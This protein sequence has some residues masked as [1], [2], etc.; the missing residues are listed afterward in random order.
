MGKLE[1]TFILPPFS[2]FDTKQG[3]WQS[4]KRKWMELG[5]RSEEGRGDNLLKFSKTVQMKKNREFTS[6]YEGGD[7][8]AGSGTS[9]FDPVLCEI[10]Y[11]WFCPLNGKIFDNFAGGSV[12]GIV[13]A[14]LGYKYTGIDLSETQIVA[15]RKQAEELV[16]ENKPKWI[17]GD[18][19]KSL[20]LDEDTDYDLIFTCP[21]YYDLE[22]YSDG[23]NDMST[24][25]DYNAFIDMYEESMKNAIQKLKNNRFMIYTITNIR[26]KHGFYRDFVCDTIRLAKK[27]GLHFYNDIILINS[28]GTLAMRINRQFS[29]YR[30]V[31]KMHQNVLVFYK[32]NDFKQIN[33]VF[34]N[35]DTGD[36]TQNKLST[37][38]K[39]PK[40]ASQTTYEDDLLALR[41]EYPG[42]CD[43]SLKKIMKQMENT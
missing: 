6:K 26:D 17:I 25:G 4:R 28:V 33:E 19:R 32:G 42:I 20:E 34:G 16:P 29:A 7:A 36:V 3:Y 35:I 11:K 23:P 22:V 1:S 30:K 15:N 31:G 2:V 21:P 24:A 12:R 18:S 10:C 37:F 39:T 40:P 14:K 5:I 43:E 41:E 9:I 8:W 38:F 13:A 27:H